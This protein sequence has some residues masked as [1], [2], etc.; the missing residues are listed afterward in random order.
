[1]ESAK[2]LELSNA[3]NTY[4]NRTPRHDRYQ[5][6]EVSMREPYTPFTPQS[7]PAT[8]D[9]TI[10]GKR[11]SFFCRPRPL[12]RHTA[13]AAVSPACSQPPPS[14]SATLS[15]SPSTPDLLPRI[16]DDGT[17]KGRPSQSHRIG[18]TSHRLPAGTSTSPRIGPGHNSQIA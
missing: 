16:Q 14:K 18:H 11:T 15:L 7:Q 1:M 10:S 13:L 6:R 9:I 3:N 5:P 12:P 2:L 4:N 8:L 17:T